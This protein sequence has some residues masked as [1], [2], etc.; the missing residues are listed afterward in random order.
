[1]QKST[2]SL[3]LPKL[4]SFLCCAN[5]GVC[6]VSLNEI[7]NETV[8]QEK[9]K[10]NKLK[11]SG[12]IKETVLIWSVETSLFNCMPTWA[13]IN[14]QFLIML[15]LMYLNQCLWLKFSEFYNTRT[16]TVIIILRQKNFTL[17]NIN[18]PK[19]RLPYTTYPFS[20]NYILRSNLH[21]YI[22]WKKQPREFARRSRNFP[23]VYHFINSSNLS[24]SLCI[25]IVRR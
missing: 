15:H 17:Y 4:V 8:N 3:K 10:K 13:A 6:Y 7:T 22:L 5:C 14:S 1:M 2:I 23:F 16:V 21:N 20:S 19:N 9:E 11:S 24:P 12:C 18:S 25:D